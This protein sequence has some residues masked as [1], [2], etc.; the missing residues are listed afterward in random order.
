METNASAARTPRRTAPRTTNLDDV[1]RLSALDQSALLRSGQVSVEEL[2][3]ACFA[4][5]ARWEPGL[6]AFVEQASRRASMAARA[7]DRDRRRRPSAERGPLW[8]LPT[9]MKDIQLVRGMPMRLGS[10]AFRYLW[11]PFDDITT[12][13]LRDAGLVILGKLATSEMAIL[14]FVD[15]DIHPPCRNPWDM[16]R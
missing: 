2:T 11:S 10:R 16:T 8:G 6:G 7:L 4:R 1:A 14:P 12:R 9:A 15:T 3:R 13:A 5:I